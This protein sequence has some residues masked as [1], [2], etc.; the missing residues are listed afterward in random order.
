MEAQREQ[1]TAVCEKRVIS[2]WELMGASCLS[3]QGLGGMEV[4]RR[5]GERVCHSLAPMNALVGLE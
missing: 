3:G 2:L 4:G 1:Q 5:G